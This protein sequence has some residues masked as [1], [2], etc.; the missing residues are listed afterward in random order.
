MLERQV[1]REFAWRRWVSIA[2]TLFVAL[3]L[4]D[5]VLLGPPIFGLVS[6]G[7]HN[8]LYRTTHTGGSESLWGLAVAC[9]VL[10]LATLM[11]WW[12]Q[13]WLVS[14]TITTA[15]IHEMLR[16]VEGILADARLQPPQ[17]EILCAE[18]YQELRQSLSQVEYRP[19]GRILRKRLRGNTLVIYSLARAVVC[20][21]GRRKVPE[22]AERLEKLPSQWLSGQPVWRAAPDQDR[23]KA[24]AV[25]LLLYPLYGR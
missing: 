13:A 16:L 20:T 23:E 1:V 4:L 8:M 6:S 19:L 17:R 11:L 12:T 24:E 22:S 3:V 7:V 9:L 25:T 18:L 2:R 21:F 5:L 10:V 14:R 15:V